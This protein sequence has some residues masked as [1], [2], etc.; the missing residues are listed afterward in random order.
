[1]DALARSGRGT[2][3]WAHLWVAVQ[4]EHLQLLQLWEGALERGYTDASACRQVQNPAGH[5][6]PESAEN[7]NSWDAVD[8]VLN[9]SGSGWALVHLLGLYFRPCSRS[10]F[11]LE[12]RGGSQQFAAGKNKPQKG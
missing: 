4:V 8:A 6:A 2:P 1:M 10:G 11:C 3:E 7:D 12:H 5:A 9:Q